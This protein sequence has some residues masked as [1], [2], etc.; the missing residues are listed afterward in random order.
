MDA[1]KTDIRGFLGR[2]FRTDALRDDDDIFALG[3]VN[4]MFAMQIVMFLEGQ[5]GLTVENED[6]ELDNFRSVAAMSR[7]VG[8]KR[9]GEG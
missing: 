5:Y 1:I 6:L 8:R 7:F 9:G 4:S 2:H 3:L